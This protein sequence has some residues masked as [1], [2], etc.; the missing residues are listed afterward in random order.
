MIGCI[1]LT[2]LLLSSKPIDKIGVGG[3]IVYLSPE[4]TIGKEFNLSLFKNIDNNFSKGIH[5]GYWD[6]K[7]ELS[8]RKLNWKS[9]YLG[10]GLK[11]RYP[12]KNCLYWGVFAN[13]YTVWLKDEHFPINVVDNSCKSGFVVSVDVLSVEFPVSGKKLWVN[14]RVGIKCN[15]PYDSVGVLQHNFPMGY[16]IINIERPL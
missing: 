6:A 5:I 7:R 4:E 15:F 11:W 2:I 9:V 12:Q 1:T 8:T 3:G 10:A 16:L 13:V 14:N